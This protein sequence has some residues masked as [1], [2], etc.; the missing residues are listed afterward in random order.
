MGAV[1]CYLCG[2]EPLPL[3]EVQNA[4]GMEVCPRRYLCGL[5]PLPFVEAQ[6]AV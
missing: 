5:E 2:L 6:S 1:S 3:V 4:V